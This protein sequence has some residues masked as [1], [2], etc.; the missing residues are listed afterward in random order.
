[1]TKVPSGRTPRLAVT[2][3]LLPLSEKLT[4]VVPLPDRWPAP[5]EAMSRLV[6]ESVTWG[7]TVTGGAPWLA[8]TANAPLVRSTHRLVGNEAVGEVAPGG[9]MATV[10]WPV[11]QRWPAPTVDPQMATGAAVFASVTVEMTAAIARPGL[12]DPSGAP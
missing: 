1:M 8:L 7:V 10:P 2:D 5:S 3:W 6:F 9:V 11:S 4:V 12:H